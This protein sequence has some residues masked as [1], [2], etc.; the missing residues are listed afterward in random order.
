MDLIT[1]NPGALHFCPVLQVDVA[2]QQERLGER[3]WAVLAGLGRRRRQAGGWVSGLLVL[4]QRC[5]CWQDE[6]AN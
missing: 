5:Q 1:G 2:E 6:V 3:L 4:L